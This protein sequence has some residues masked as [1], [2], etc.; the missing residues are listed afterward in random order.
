[1]RALTALLLILCLGLA[2]CGG[3]EETTD[4]A[5]TDSASASAPAE[6]GADDTAGDDTAAAEGIDADQCQEIAQ[7][8]AD[9]STAVGEAAAGTGD[10]AAIQAQADAFAEVADQVPA[11]FSADF[12]VVADAFSEIA[13][14]LAEVDLQPGEVPDAEAQAALTELGTTLSDSEYATASA[15]ISTYFAGG[16]Q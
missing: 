9:A 10:T 14:T 12:Q 8:L 6:E 11:E 16:C 15:N 13:S 4:T 1:M 5:D 7:A 3:G 2:A